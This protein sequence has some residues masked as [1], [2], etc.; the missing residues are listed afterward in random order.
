MEITIPQKLKNHLDS[1]SK[2]SALV[3]TVIKNC[4]DYF[5]QDPPC[6]FPEYNLHAIDHINAVLN[7]SEKLITLEGINKLL[8][9]DI[10]V[11]VCSIIFH[12]LGMFVTPIG[13]QKLLFG[14]DCNIQ[15]DDITFAKRWTDYLEKTLRKSNEDIIKTFGIIDGIKV[16]PRDIKK[17]TQDDFKV[18]G[19]FVRK[20]HHL[21]SYLFVIKYF[22]GEKDAD[23]FSDTFYAFESANRNSDFEHVRK[24][25]ALIAKSH[26]TSIRETEPQLISNF[27]NDST[28]FCKALGIPVFYIMAIVRLADL[29]D[30]GEHRAPIAIQNAHHLY[31]EVSQFEWAWNQRINKDNYYWIAASKVLYIFVTP[32]SGNEFIKI[33]EWLLY[34]QYEIDLSW[35]ILA[36]YYSFEYPI[37]IHRM[38]SNILDFAAIA[39]YENRFVTK[40]AKFE[41][42]P[43][44]LKLLIQPL[45]GDNPTFGVRELLQNSIDACKEREVISVGGYSEGEK[46]KIE[47]RIDTKAKS[48][49][50]IDNGI[51]MTEEI[52]LNYFLAIGTSYR[53]SEDYY[54]K[55]VESAI[56]TIA[57]SG[58]FGIGVLAMFLIGKNAEIITRSCEG[59]LGYGFKLELEQDNIEIRR[60][61]IVDCSI[62]TSI[63]I[64]IDDDTFGFFTDSKNDK[65]RQS[66]YHNYKFEAVDWRNWYWLETPTINYYIDEIIQT[67]PN[68]LFRVSDKSSSKRNWFKLNSSKYTDYYWTYSRVT[69]SGRGYRTDFV[70]SFCNGIAIPNRINATSLLNTCGLVIPIPTLSL[71]DP[72]SV[73][74]LS[75]SR[76]CLL[77]LPD[78][79]ILI[80]ELYKYVLAK[81][82]IQDFTSAEADTE[83]IFGGFRCFGDKSSS[84]YF[85]YYLPGDAP[86]ILSNNGFTILSE[87]FI[88][89]AQINRIMVACIDTG[90]KNSVLNIFD[91]SS[92]PFCVIPQNKKRFAFQFY[93]GI[94][95][96][97][98]FYSGM[99]LGY[100]QFDYNQKNNNYY[101]VRRKLLNWY[102]EKSVYDDIKGH[103][104]K[105]IE[106]TVAVFDDKGDYYHLCFDKKYQQA[107]RFEVNETIPTVLDIEL[108]VISNITSNLIFKI[109]QDYLGDDIWIPFEMDERRKKFPKAFKELAHYMI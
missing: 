39:D 40:R 78:S 46:P 93:N 63:T 19:E 49:S 34:L 73:L 68:D 14:T 90:K 26:G 37:G 94:L 5:R 35:A 4:I 67:K 6:F 13:L 7:Y 38:K 85:K 62:G 107:V 82:L 54:H 75:L 64:S 2:F 83:R 102:N 79:E 33:K 16:P 76:H 29:L 45:Y 106:K 109:F 86:F 52:I 10:A 104:P 22:L 99:F 23:I 103:L 57:R 11:L 80:N 18:Y 20:N 1:E 97:S 91:A 56:N 71:S 55:F 21:L 87:P 74:R 3:D 66:D 89:K 28:I 9:R 50:I 95:N 27:G 60:V 30:A 105:T 59:G 53:F 100:S 88:L 17:C 32:Q 96:C 108:E 24:I 25:I 12:D 84:P 41:A 70:D 81:L 43:E 101:T 15:V 47:I 61:P 58:Q 8:P 77:E 51:G 65:Y 92:M 98:V 72:N 48:F 69:A 31:S 36:E 42:K 44:L